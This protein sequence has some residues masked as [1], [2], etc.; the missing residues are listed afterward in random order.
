MSGAGFLT[1]DLNGRGGIANHNKGFGLFREAC[2]Q[3]KQT[4]NLILLGGDLQRLFRSGGG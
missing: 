4:L 3:T 1:G 2:A